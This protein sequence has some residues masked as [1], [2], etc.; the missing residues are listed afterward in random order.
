VFHRAIIKNYK[1]KRPGGTSGALGVSDFNCAGGS[2]AM[3]NGLNRALRTL[4]TWGLLR[5][6]AQGGA[7]K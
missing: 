4:E 5:G 6:T 2:A 7:V 1:S 3:V